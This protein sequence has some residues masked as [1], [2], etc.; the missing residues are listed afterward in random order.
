MKK[1]YIVPAAQRVAMN[2]E[3]VIARSV[4]MEFGTTG[5]DTQLTQGK[6]FDSPWDEEGFEDSFNDF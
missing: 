2:F 1:Q 5:S 3:G 6:T 4:T